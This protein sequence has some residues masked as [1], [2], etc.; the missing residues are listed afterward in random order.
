MF[1]DCSATSNFSEQLYHADLR[2][3]TRSSDPGK[4]AAMLSTFG[5]KTRPKKFQTASR[6]AGSKRA[7]SMEPNALSLNEVVSFLWTYIPS[8]RIKRECA[9]RRACLMDS[10]SF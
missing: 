9:R 7:V 2:R 10:E 3:N 4:T 6:H 1:R 8:T 5:L